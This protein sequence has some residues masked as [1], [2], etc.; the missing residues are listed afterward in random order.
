MARALDCTYK[1][2]HICMETRWTFDW[3]DGNAAKCEK[4]G[5]SRHEIEYA[6]TH[7]ARF[8]ADIDH[9][10]TEQRF[11]ALSR[12][13]AGRAVYIVFCWRDGRVRPI[14]ARYMHKR[15]AT[16]HGI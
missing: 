3:D 11:L 5:L 7:D 6:V 16:R 12:T 8:A 13:E 14:S 10:L 2:V 1:R 15:E 4:H 9:S